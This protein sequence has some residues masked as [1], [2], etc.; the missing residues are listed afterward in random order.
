VPTANVEM[1]HSN[2]LVT[3]D[4]IPG[5]Y[6]AYC[7]FPEVDKVKFPFLADYEGKK[8]PCALSIG[9]NPTY[10]NRKKT[11]EVFIIHDFQ[12]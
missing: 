12:N 1:N 2:I 7:Q 9:W 6:S 10:A 11:V 4:L 5:V 3:E 8:L